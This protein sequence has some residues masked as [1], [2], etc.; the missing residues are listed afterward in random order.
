ML[1]KKKQPTDNSQRKKHSHPHPEFRKT[2]ESCLEAQSLRSQL[3][4]DYNW[5]RRYETATHGGWAGAL[6]PFASPTKTH[7]PSIT[8]AQPLGNPIV[9]HGKGSTLCQKPRVVCPPRSR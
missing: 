4:P 6:F 7:N 8:P 2:T 9:S 1:Q 5:W 3:D